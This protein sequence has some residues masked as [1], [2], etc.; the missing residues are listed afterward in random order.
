MF[1]VVIKEKNKKLPK[2]MLYALVQAEMI[3]IRKVN[4]QHPHI[5]SIWTQISTV[6]ALFNQLEMQ[7]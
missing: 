2:G 7:S 3:K 5:H 6:E 4:Y 1:E